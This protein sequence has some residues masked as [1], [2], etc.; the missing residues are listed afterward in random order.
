MDVL[1]AQLKVEFDFGALSTG[2]VSDALDRCSRG[3]MLTGQQLRGMAML[4]SVAQVKFTGPYRDSCT[5]VQGLRNAILSP[6]RKERVFRDVREM[7]EVVCR[8]WSCVETDLDLLKLITFAVDEEGS[9]V[10]SASPD[11]SKTRQEFRRIRKKLECMI[12]SF[13]GEMVERS[14]RHKH[15]DTSNLY[16][17]YTGCAWQC[18]LGMPSRPMPW[19]WIQDRTGP[20][21]AN[22]EGH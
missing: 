16:I 10:D 8:P 3:G 19:S 14:G 5:F 20:C 7:A 11:L 18:L 13:K 2:L 9:L 12:R 6:F 17:F 21:I 15:L 22:H 1:A 4:I